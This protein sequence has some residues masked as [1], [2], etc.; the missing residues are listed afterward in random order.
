LAAA[1]A[2]AVV[3]SLALTPQY[4]ASATYQLS[5]TPAGANVGEVIARRAAG[6]GRSMEPVGRHE[7][8]QTSATPGNLI[9]RVEAHATSPSRATELANSYTAD[10]LALERGVDRP[11]L[12]NRI[13][14]LRRQLRKVGPTRTFQADLLA[15]RLKTLEARQITDADF[16]TFGPVTTRGRSPVRHAFYALPLALLIAFCA[17]VLLDR[18]PPRRRRR[19]SQSRL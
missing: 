1:V 16:Q 14:D 2:A 17:G 8:V 19:R 7:A 13:S 15:A 4:R 18:I 6:L 3:A 11:R 9:V 10:L 5:R 12:E